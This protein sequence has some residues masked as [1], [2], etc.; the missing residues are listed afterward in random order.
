MDKGGKS[1]KMGKKRNLKKE[2]K[3]LI[4]RE[5]LKKRKNHGEK[6]SKEYNRENMGE[7]KENLWSRL[8]PLFFLLLLLPLLR[9]QRKKETESPVKW[10]GEIW[11]KNEERI[12]V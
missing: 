3:A 7:E 12:V 11:S 5:I 9:G 4:K 8:R 1:G 6:K 2:E 10:K